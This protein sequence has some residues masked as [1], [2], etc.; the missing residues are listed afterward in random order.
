MSERA[1]AEDE[2][3]RIKSE[4]LQQIIDG[5]VEFY[6]LRL[7]QINNEKNELLKTIKELERKYKELQAK[8]DVKEQS[9]TRMKADMSDK[10]RKVNFRLFSYKKK[11]ESLST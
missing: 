5:E 2:I 7:N 4:C 6:K 3:T 11:I 1:T 10:Q 9:W 8:F